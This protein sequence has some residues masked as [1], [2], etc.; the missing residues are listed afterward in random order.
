MFGEQFGKSGN[1]DM[2]FVRS[3]SRRQGFEGRHRGRDC[4]VLV[5]WGLG[6]D[7]PGSL[8]GG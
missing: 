1:G 8:E 5:G 3:I 7:T 6:E 4:L 2:A